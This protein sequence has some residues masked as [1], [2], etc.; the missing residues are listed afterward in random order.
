M[1]VGPRL[2]SLAGWTHGLTPET[3]AAF[4]A[5]VKKSDGCWLWAGPVNRKA[6]GYGVVYARGRGRGAHRI[7]YELAHGPV[8]LGMCVCHKCDNPPCVRPGHLFLGTH[9]D[10]ADDM[11]A[12]GRGV[13]SRGDDHKRLLLTAQ[14]VLWIR[15]QRAMGRDCVEIAEELGRPLLTVRRVAFGLTWRHLAEATS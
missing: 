12:K 8:G 14:Q 5:R 7:A 4:W 9:K 1:E 10:N 6:G 11:Q 13:V 15:E 3:V 2:L